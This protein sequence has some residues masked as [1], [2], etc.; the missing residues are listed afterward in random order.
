MEEQ[1]IIQEVPVTRVYDD[2]DI[3]KFGVVRYCTKC[4]TSWEHIYL[5]KA[6][7]E[8][9]PGLPTI[10]LA[11]RICPPCEKARTV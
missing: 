7:V 8:K 9:Y 4:S 3:H 11:R 2:R 1:W 6:F 10:G 5:G